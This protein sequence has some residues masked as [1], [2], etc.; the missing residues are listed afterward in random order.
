MRSKTILTTR[1]LRLRTW[2]AED[3]RAY[4]LHCNNENVMEHLGGVMSPR[5][6]KLEVKWFIRHQQ[7]HGISFWVIERKC[8]RAFL[9]FCGLIRVA[10]PNSTVP[11]KIEIG[12]RVRSDMWRRGYAYEAAVATLK[13]GRD[14]FAETIISRVIPRLSD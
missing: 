10:E 3:A 12:W 9:G 2:R 13:Y 6:L 4:Q 11:G 8:D 5:Q 1:R 7:R 14:Q